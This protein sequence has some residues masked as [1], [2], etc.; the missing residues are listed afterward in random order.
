MRTVS[1]RARSGRIHQKKPHSAAFFLD[2]SLFYLPAGIPVGCMY[3]SFQ[4]I[5]MHRNSNTESPTRNAKARAMLLVL[6]LPSVPFLI[7]KKSA[8]ARLA[9]MAVNANATK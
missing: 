8:K 1:W 6:R 9:T 2:L 7:M 5:R 4:A 3:P